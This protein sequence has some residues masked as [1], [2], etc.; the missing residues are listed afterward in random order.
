MNAV[1]HAGVGIGSNGRA[2]PRTAGG[3]G[4]EAGEGVLRGLE[5]LGADEHGAPVVAL[6]EQQAIGPPVVTVEQ[7]E[8]VVDVA[9]ALRHLLA[10]GVDHEA[11]VDP[12]AGE[13]L[14]E[15]DR[16]RPL[17]LVMREAQVHPSG[18]EVE[19]FPEQVEA[20]H[21][22]LGVPPG[23]PFTPRRRPR[24]LAGLGELP[25]REVAGMTLGLGA[26]HLPL[27]TTGDQLVERLVG[28]QAVVLDALD[29]EVDPVLG[30][31]RAT[32]LDELADHGH[33]LVDVGR[34]VGN[35][36][37]MGDPEPVHRHPPHPLAPLGD[38]VPRAL[39]ALGPLDDAV[40][41]VGHVGDQP[42]IHALPA[43]VTDQDVVLEREPAVTEVRRGVHRGA[44][45]VDAH[46]AGLA[47]GELTNLPRGGVVQAEHAPNDKSRSRRSPAWFGPVAR[48]IALMPR[49]PDKP[50][51]D[52]V[53]T[54]W[55][56][57]WEADGV[58]RFD[59]DALDGRDRTGVFV[60]DTPPPTVSGS[61]HMGNI[62]G[63]THT[64]CIVRYQRMSGKVV[65]YPIGWDD[66]GLATERRVQN[67][68]GVRCDPTQHYDPEFQA[69]YRGDTP[70]GHQEVPISRPNFIELCHELTATD[71]AVFEDTFRRL[72][73]SYDW[74]LLYTTINDV[75]RRTSQLAFLRNLGRG[76][77]YSAEAPTL[78]DVDDRTAVAQAEIEDRERPGAYHLLAFHGPDGP[79]LIDTTRPELVVSCVALVA[80]PDDER[81]RGLFG[82]TVRTPVFGVEVPV[83]SHP[84]A[85]PEKGTGIAM[86]CTFGDT[87]DVTWWR[88]MDLPTRSVIGRDGRFSTATPDWIP[89]EEGKGRLPVTRRSDRQ[90]GPGGDGR[91]V[92]RVGR[93]ARR[94]PA[95]H[96]PGQVLRTR[97]APAR[98]RH[99]PAVVHPQRR[100]RSG[101]ARG[102]PRPRQGARLV[103]R[104]HAPP[105][106]ALGRGA[107][108]RLAGQPPAVLRR[109]DPA[110]VPARR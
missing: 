17:V 48:S 109:A 18:V 26:D 23:P 45:E 108:R 105:L 60:V 49:V 25:E 2:D 13:A 30:R 69:P 39:F 84:L 92:A 81:F 59:R 42:H 98:D 102:V 24:R 16:L 78:W 43:Q 12:V 64:D 110:V 94:R 74:S 44:A 14:P 33:H 7:V 85:D 37:G 86:V 75:S 46:L 79:V 50:T 36:I 103:P 97:A 87:S 91:P 104:P 61:I 62:F 54:R 107:Q 72:G 20:H 67:Y 22:A 15:R 95:D 21:H 58:Y 88:E 27:A 8:Q 51:L 40:V 32:D 55:A 29:G 70:S 35:V 41:D 34:G 63:Y 90:A 83:V 10:L 96:P 53:E 11:V 73:L 4:V 80:H 89:T 93:P 52:G 65:Y 3:E 1:E 82:S 9:Q 6:Q 99:Q 56:E 100:A 5:V 38:L 71:E 106:R 31:V 76:E 19:P 68:F 101:P 77:A 57:R 47:H 28:E 66:N